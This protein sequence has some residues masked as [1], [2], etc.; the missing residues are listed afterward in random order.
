[1]VSNI[2]AFFPCIAQKGATQ[3]VAFGIQNHHLLPMEKLV[4]DRTEIELRAPL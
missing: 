2:M 1:M 4:H 3:N